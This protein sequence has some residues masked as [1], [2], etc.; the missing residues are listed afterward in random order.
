MVLRTGYGGVVADTDSQ[1]DEAYDY[2]ERGVVPQTRTN[3]D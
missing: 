1:R 3:K 2:E